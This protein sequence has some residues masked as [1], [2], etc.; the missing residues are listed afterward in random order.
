MNHKQAAKLKI[1]DRVEIWPDTDE[2][3]PGTV[4]EANWC[5]VKIEYD[6]GVLGTI[7]HRDMKEVRR[8]EERYDVTKVA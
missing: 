2:A 7:H 8:L 5:A 3:C 1:G 4:I 6:D